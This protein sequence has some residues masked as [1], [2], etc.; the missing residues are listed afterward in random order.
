[1]T[2]IGDFPRRFRP[3]F[4]LG[5]FVQADSVRLGFGVV[6]LE[7][8]RMVYRKGWGDIDA[9]VDTWFGHFGIEVE[10]GRFEEDANG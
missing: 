9:Y 8:Y 5:V 10:Y 4:R 2:R 7:V 1:M 3:F 6:S